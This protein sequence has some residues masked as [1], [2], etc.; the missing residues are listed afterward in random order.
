MDETESL[1]A[2]SHQQLAI[3]IE[4]AELV[5]ETAEKARYIQQTTG[6]TSVEPQNL[7]PPLERAIEAVTAEYSNADVQFSGA[8]DVTVLA[9]E[10]LD[11]ALR[12]AIENGIVHQETD[13]PTVV[14]AVSTPSEDMARI[15]I[16]NEGT[17]PDSE[18]YTL[19]KDEETPLEHSSGLGL[20][21]VKWIVETAHGSI[22]FSDS[23]SGEVC[24]QIELYR[25]PA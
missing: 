22:E 25:V 21:L 1:S 11:V 4:H 24:L 3:A 5:V 7:T 14:V 20:W 18:R 9:D 16:R 23:T 12:E 19:E 17:I 2:E 10:N 15:E 6:N 8:N 13:S